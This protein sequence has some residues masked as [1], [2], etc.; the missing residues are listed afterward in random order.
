M[1]RHLKTGLFTHRLDLADQFPDKTF[2]NQFRRQVYIQGYGNIIVPLGYIPFCLRHVDQ[3]VFLR[4]RHLFAAKL[5]R[6]SALLLQ[7]VHGLV[8]VNLGQGFPDIAQLL[9]ILGAHRL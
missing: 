6:Q 8:A 9:A 1:V 7:G 2:L 5:E 4:Q 3:Q